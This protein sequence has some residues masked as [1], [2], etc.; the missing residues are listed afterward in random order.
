M[1]ALKVYKRIMHLNGNIGF[2]MK[3]HGI[4]SG[5]VQFGQ[6][7]LSDFARA[8]ETRSATRCCVSHRD[9]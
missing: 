9:N 2:K 4:I 3:G 1:N 5:L 7:S 6:T 8:V